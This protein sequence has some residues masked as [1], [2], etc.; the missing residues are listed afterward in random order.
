MKIITISKG[1]MDGIYWR[2][3]DYISPISNFTP[4]ECVE[5]ALEYIK[6]QK[7]LD[8][9]DSEVD[10]LGDGFR[11]VHYTYDRLCQTVYI[12]KEKNYV[13]YEGFVSRNAIHE[14]QTFDYMHL[15]MENIDLLC[16]KY[17]LHKDEKYYNINNKKMNKVNALILK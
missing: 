14:I 9:Y 7:I 17:R 12:N 2:L 10:W 11:L 8:Y 5:H 13:F 6:E 3:S 4:N 1:Q 16:K 15:N